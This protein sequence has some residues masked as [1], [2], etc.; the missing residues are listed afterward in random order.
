MLKKHTTDFL[1]YCKVAD[2][3]AKSIESLGISLREFTACIAAKQID[4]IKH[5]TYG[6]L[7]DFVADFKT[8]SIH[9]K[10]ARV[11]CLHQFFHFLT[12]SG[13]IEENIAL[14]LPYPKIEKTVPNFL[15]IEEFNRIVEFFNSNTDSVN[16]LRN[17]V[18]IL[19]LGNSIGDARE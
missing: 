19:I 12:V 11:W 3:A 15:T 16:G 5:I 13:H 7:Y 4:S 18:M 10:K 9:K 6:H 14:G 1:A 17:L 2:F 8:P